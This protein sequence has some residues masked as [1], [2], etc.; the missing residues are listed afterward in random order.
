[1]AQRLLGNRFDGA[2]ETVLGKVVGADSISARNG[3]SSKDCPNIS[4]RQTRADMESAPKIVLLS[5]RFEYT[6]CGLLPCI[7]N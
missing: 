1:M 4:A 3:K 2:S 5:K 6:A 7:K